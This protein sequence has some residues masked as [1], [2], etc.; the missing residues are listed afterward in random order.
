MQLGIFQLL[1]AKQQQINVGLQYIEGL[2]EYW[3]A[4]TALEQILN[5]GQVGDIETTPMAEIAGGAVPTI[6]LPE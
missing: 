6:S 5:G 4:C 3:H 2:N 1:L